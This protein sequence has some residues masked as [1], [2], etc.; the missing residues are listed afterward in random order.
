MTSHTKNQPN[1]MTNH[2]P[3]PTCDKTISDATEAS[4]CC[5]V[6][7]LWIYFKC[8]GLSKKQFLR[9]GND[10]TPWFC[11]QC[12]NEAY[13]FHGLDNQKFRN[14][15]CKSQVRS[16]EPSA[17]FAKQLSFKSECSVRSR[18]RVINTFKGIPCHHCQSLKAQGHVTV[19]KPVISMIYIVSH[20]WPLC[21]AQILVDGVNPR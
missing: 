17:D 1:I 21:S 12:A 11:K 10:T 13:P 8:S 18:R 14:F 19:N 6:C 4:I 5:D 3:C 20:T 7:G 9:L 2:T 15:I 16:N